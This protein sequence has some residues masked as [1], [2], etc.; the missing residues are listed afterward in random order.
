VLSLNYAIPRLFLQHDEL[1]ADA[2]MAALSG[3]Y[4]HPRKFRRDVIVESLMTAET[5]GLLEEVGAR[6]DCKQHVVISYCASESGRLM[7]GRHLGAYLTLAHNQT[8]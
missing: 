4:G 8:H 7:I 3:D 6:L 5:N 1:D 2:V